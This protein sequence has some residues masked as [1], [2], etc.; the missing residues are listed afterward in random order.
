MFGSKSWPL[1][2]EGTPVFQA[3]YV[4]NNENFLSGSRCVCMGDDICPVVPPLCMPVNLVSCDLARAMR[5]AC[6]SLGLLGWRLGLGIACNARW[7]SVRVWLCL[8]DESRP[9]KIGGTP[10]IF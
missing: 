8:L 4:F 2:A 3:L 6:S 5:G 10:V 7:L 1:R 9:S